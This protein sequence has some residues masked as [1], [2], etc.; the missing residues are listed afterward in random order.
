MSTRAPKSVDLL[1]L[2]LIAVL[3]IIGFFIFS[4]ASLG[5]LARD[6]ASFSSVAFNQ[7]FFGVVGGGLTLLVTTNIYYR[8]WRQYAFY[9]FI[10]GILPPVTV[11]DVGGY[12]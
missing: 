6:G 8:N 4:S 2:G 5:L 11:I 9:I 10:A 3:T 1:L 12:K 7:F